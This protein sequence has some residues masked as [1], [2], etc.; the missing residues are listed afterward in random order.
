MKHVSGSTRRRHPLALHLLSSMSRTPH[1]WCPVDPSDVS[2][3]LAAALISVCIALLMLPDVG[4]AGEAGE[5][6][7]TMTAHRTSGTRPCG[8]RNCRPDVGPR[9]GVSCPSG[10]VLLRP[11]K[12]LQG[13]IDANG[14]GTV[15]CLRRGIY[16]LKGPLLPKSDD[17]FLGEYGAVLSGSRI[18]SDWVQ[19]D[20]Y[21]VATDQRQE[22]EVIPG[23]PCL[24]GIECN[25][26]EGLFVGSRQL[27]QVTS[28]SAVR[29]G[30]FFFD[31]AT[32]TIYMRDDPRG[33]RVEASVATGAFRSTD[34]Y[35]E[36][37]VIRNLVIE[38]FANPSRTGAIYTSVSPRWVVKDSEVRENHGAGIAHTDGAKIL[39]N[40]IHHNG[41]IGVGGY[42]TRNVLVQDNEI[43]RNAI[44][45]FD[46]WEAGGAKYTLSSGLTFRG[47]YVH[48]NRHH[49]LW[50]D[51]DNIGITYVRNTIVGNAGSGIFHEKSGRCLIRGNYIAGNREDGIFIST[52]SNVEVDGNALVKNRAWGVH[53]FVSGPD[54]I[55]H[56]LAD[57][58]I[59]DNRFVVRAGT[60]NG[61][62]TSDV[63]D[64]S[65][66]STSKGNRF[67]SNHYSVPDLTG[68]YWAWDDQLLSWRGWRAEGQDRTGTVR[69]T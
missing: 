18:V 24:S 32:D 53:L 41:Q 20:G 6:Q 68:R 47:N 64:P 38:R 33:E 11:G 49:G 13:A 4:R 19:R 29:R 59:H 61:I 62:Q 48:D 69:A 12:N 34:H 27:I 14:P 35:A 3:R 40:D 51:T 7:T 31:Y 5:G 9:R 42:R 65:R 66:Y 63:G 10:S 36:N 43:A 2:R 55:D 15:F 44:G 46:G 52:S 45:G 26:P 37:V 21:W 60:P 16:R 39:N 1:A 30:R 17:V 8:P 25:R 58:V 28:L 67:R 50:T 57:N 54:T 56:D 22:N 23:V